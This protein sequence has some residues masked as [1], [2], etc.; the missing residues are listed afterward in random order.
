MSDRYVLRVSGCTTPYVSGGPRF[1]WP[2]LLFASPDG[3]IRWTVEASGASG[4]A[5]QMSGAVRLLEESVLERNQRAV[6]IANRTP[7]P[8]WGQIARA[9]ACAECGLYDEAY[10]DLLGALRC[11]G[12]RARVAH[13]AL[14]IVLHKSAARAPDDIDPASAEWA[15]QAAQEH[16]AAATSEPI[17]GLAAAISKKAGLS[18]IVSEQKKCMVTNV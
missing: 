8:F 12:D 5:E 17:A 9:L 16:F 3:W 1:A 7:D 2:S 15:L 14:A 6:K 4:R 11:G 13:R 18:Q 10:W